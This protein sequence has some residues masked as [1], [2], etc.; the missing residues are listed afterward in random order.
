MCITDVSFQLS[1]PNCLLWEATLLNIL[2]THQMTIAKN[3]SVAIRPFDTVQVKLCSKIVA[4]SG[5]GSRFEVKQ[6]TLAPTIV[7]CCCCGCYLFFS[8]L[9]SFV[10]LI[11]FF[12]L[13]FFLVF[14]YILIN[15]A[16]KNC[17]YFSLVG[18][19]IEIMKPREKIVLLFDFS[20][21]RELIIW[22]WQYT[23]MTF[24]FLCLEV[25]PFQ[26]RSEKKVDPTKLTDA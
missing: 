1:I 15:E 16:S 8:F 14:F 11:C 20:A 3:S 22:N 13:F 5:V 26:K 12:F 21:E 9:H 2:V 24:L 25:Q 18:I 19:P 4:I 17:C 6:I 23:K 10:F 7:R